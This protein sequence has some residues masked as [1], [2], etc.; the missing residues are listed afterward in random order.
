MRRFI[1]GSETGNPRAILFSMIIAFPVLLLSFAAMKVSGN[2]CVDCGTISCPTCAGSANWGQY[3]DTGCPAN[4]QNESGWCCNNTTPIV[5]DVDGTGFALTSL[6]DGVFFDI[7]VKGRRNQT[8]WTAGQSTNAWLALDRNGNGKIDNGSELFGNLTPQ[9]D[10]PKGQ[11]RNGFLALAVFDKPENGGNGNGLLDD[12]D[13]IY[14]KLLLWQDENHD[15][16]SQPKELK[17]LAD[18]GIKAI[19]LHYELNNYTD[20]FGNTFRYRSKIYRAIGYHDSRF[21]YDVLL[22]FGRASRPDSG[23]ESVATEP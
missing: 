7:L 3:P 8:S 12:K 14:T 11:Y 2:Q 21:A 19:D 22:R 23:S 18:F 17:H 13:A 6:A 1:K 4:T 15:G 5:I 20:Q 16:V 9:P 10:P